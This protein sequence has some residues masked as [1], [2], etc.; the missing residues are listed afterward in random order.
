MER[1]TGLG[2]LLRWASSLLLV[3]LTWNPTG[4]SYTHWLAGTLPS[5]R[6]AQGL[7]GLILLGGWAFSLHATWRSLGHFGVLLALGIYAALIWL[8]ASQ[9]WIN[10]TRG[11]SLGWIAVVLFGSLMTVGL[12]WSLV[13]RQITGQVDVDE[14]PGR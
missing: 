1:L 4:M 12:C 9:G 10:P 7:V 3:A 13:Q 14:V 2:F 8:L 5:V 11:E 6:P